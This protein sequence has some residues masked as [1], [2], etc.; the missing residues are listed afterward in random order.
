MMGSKE[1]RQV[2]RGVPAD[3]FVERLEPEGAWMRLC[4]SSIAWVVMLVFAA[5]TAGPLWA[6][7]GSGS[8]SG[9]VKQN[10]DLPF[11]A[12]GEEE[13]EED[14]PEIIV[15]YGQQYEGDGI[16]FSC[17][18]SGSMREGGKWERLQ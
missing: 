13:D 1:I 15:F 2:P 16:F 5:G 14:A 4:G 8:A 7:T 9:G 6:Q 17:D 10:L 18:K 11:D 3:L 12:A